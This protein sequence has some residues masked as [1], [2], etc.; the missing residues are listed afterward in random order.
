[1]H[2][3]VLPIYSYENKFYASMLLKKDE[4]KECA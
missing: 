4:E 2:R 1:M 3:E